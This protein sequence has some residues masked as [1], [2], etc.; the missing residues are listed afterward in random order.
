[1]PF[2]VPAPWD[3]IPLFRWCVR[4]V[5]TRVPEG[6]EFCFFDAVIMPQI[7]LLQ[8]LLKLI[9][10]NPQPIAPLNSLIEPPANDDPGVIEFADT[11]KVHV[12]AQLG[13]DRLDGAVPFVRQ[14]QLVYC[15]SFK[16]VFGAV[17]QEPLLI[18]LA[19]LS[20]GKLFN[21]RLPQPLLLLQRRVLVAH[22]A[23]LL[24]ALLGDEVLDLEPVQQALVVSLVG[25]E[26][27]GEVLDAGDVY[28]FHCF[29][30]GFAG[31]LHYF[32]LRHFLMDIF[33]YLIHDRLCNLTL[34]LI[35]S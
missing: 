27:G 5:L 26:A 33:R 3:G 31:H 16:H 18:K 7:H 23:L 25:R 15:F 17:V 11:F 4:A 13:H 29:L 22:L 24:E 2:I 20:I 6:R 34:H 14:Q 12:L 32:F 10:P 30:F 28:D 8:L 35:T 19:M 9:K 1:M 21:E